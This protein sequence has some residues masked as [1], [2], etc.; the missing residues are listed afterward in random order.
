MEE[1]L[2]FEVT[3]LCKVVLV[4]ETNPVICDWLVA[5][6]KPCNWIKRELLTFTIVY[7][8]RDYGF[9]LNVEIDGKVGSGIYERVRRGGYYSMEVDFDD[10]LERYADAFCI[11]LKQIF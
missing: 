4:D 1:V 7:E 11:E 3:D 9:N 6:L 2:R 10:Y 8:P 5:R